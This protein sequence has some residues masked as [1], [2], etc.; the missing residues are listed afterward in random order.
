[1]RTDAIQ[2]FSTLDLGNT[3]RNDR[4]LKVAEGLSRFTGASL[5]KIFRDPSELTATYRFIGNP[6]VR[7]NDLLAPHFDQTAFRAAACDTPLLVIH[8]GTEMSFGGSLR[9]EGLGT[10][11]NGSQGFIA[12]LSLLVTVRPT[13]VD[14]LGIVAA[15]TV[16]REGYAEGSTKKPSALGTGEESKLWMKNIREAEER[17]GQPNE[18][19]PIHVMDRAA[20]AYHR[21]CELSE[22]ACRFIIRM[23]HDR[24]VSEGDEIVALRKAITQTQPIVFNRTVHL[25]ARHT[26]EIPKNNKN[27][28]QIGL[29]EATRQF[30]SR[31]SIAMR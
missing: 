1:M 13:C 31:G 3:L 11:A 5:P 15:N 22:E 12:H 30:W 19:R 2:E 21:I 14:P 9:R 17:L 29:S 26:G 24:R 7:M 23:K 10:L 20:D 16:F 6:K 28:K 25:N 27:L 18:R 8:D 4:A